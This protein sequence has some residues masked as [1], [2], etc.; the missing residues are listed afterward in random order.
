M[1]IIIRSTRSSPRIRYLSCR[2]DRT[3]IF[4]LDLHRKYNVPSRLTFPTW[5]ISTEAGSLTYARRNTFEHAF[6]PM[7]SSFQIK[8]QS[9]IQL[10]LWLA[11]ILIYSC[12]T[13][14]TSHPEIFLCIVIVIIHTSSVR[15][16]YAD[17]TV[18][19]PFSSRVRNALNA[20]AKS[21]R[22][23][24]LVGAGGLWYGFG[25]IIMRL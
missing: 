17:F 21:V 14:E 3:C 19:P 13:R 4:T 16:D 20:E 5:A 18:P 1:T 12:V 6:L 11:F 15:S 23:S 25:K 10:P 22:L 24:A 9:K 7:Y 8:A 2:L